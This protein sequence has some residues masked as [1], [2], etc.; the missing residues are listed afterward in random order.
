MQQLVI[1]VNKHEVT[2]R[3]WS[4]SLYGQG[5]HSAR[6]SQ[7]LVRQKYDH[8]VISDRTQ[9]SDEILSQI[10]RSTDDKRQRIH[11]H[12]RRRTSGAGSSS[13]PKI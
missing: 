4:C 7:R 11:I 6:L 8:K 1:I 2:Q 13:E 10:R 3:V 9:A 12:S 5:P